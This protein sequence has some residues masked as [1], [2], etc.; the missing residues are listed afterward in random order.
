[1]DYQEFREHIKENIKGAMPEKYQKATVSIQSVEKNNGMMLDGLT[2]ILPDSSISP[3]IYLNKWY[4]NYVA[5]ESMENTL[6][7][8]SEAIQRNTKFN[9]FD[10][11]S[12][13]EFE[14][15]KNHII[16][17]VV[18]LDANRN[19]LQGLPHTVQE[20]MAFTYHIMVEHDKS[21]TGTIPIS[22]TIFENYPIT[23]E[24]LHDIAMKNTVKQFPVI[25]QNMQ[26]V[27]R[28]IMG[29]E[30]SGADFIEEDELK[31]ALDETFND[32]NRE[33]VFPM[34][35]I[36]NKEKLNGAA[37]LFYP[38]V[39]E[40]IA[41]KLG[42]N[43]FIL[44]SSVHE[45][46]IVPDNGAIKYHELKDMVQEVNA[47]QVAVDEVL[48]GQVYSYDAKDKIFERADQK[49]VRNAGK[50]E[51]GEERPA[52]MD[53]LRENR[54][55]VKEKGNIKTVTKKVEAGLEI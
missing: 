22:Q 5:G 47:T 42:G 48:T 46:L 51:K 38:G 16:L 27:M 9:Q 18:G 24:E 33:E 10:I 23:V 43:F 3:A 13:L 20:D 34:Y 41:E 12:V 55:A 31:D 4:E 17:K 26:E 29:K 15:V 25:L 50:K 32:R 44:P 8:I 7:H 36:T 37:A 19:R 52:I 30:M 49:E 2:V 1:M 53:K 54:E 35:V 21:G 39:M 45:M 28:E 40:L 6:Q 11:P 14:N